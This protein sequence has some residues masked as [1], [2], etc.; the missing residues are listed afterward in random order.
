MIFQERLNFETRPVKPSDGSPI[1]LHERNS[2]WRISAIPKQNP[3]TLQ[4]T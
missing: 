3:S 2:D 4:A 1:R